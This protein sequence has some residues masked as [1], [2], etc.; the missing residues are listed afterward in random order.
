ML[1]IYASVNWIIIG[2]GNGLSPV[3]RQGITGTDA[4][5]LSIGSSGTNFS[6]IRVKIQTFHK[7]AFKN[8][9]CET[10]AILSREEWVSWS[11]N[12]VFSLS[13]K[14]TSGCRWQSCADAANT[15]HSMRYNI[16]SLT[17]RFSRRFHDPPIGV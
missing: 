1:H 2:S 6:E 4:D 10:A 17:V 13:V 9:F 14:G 16:T 8:V 5:L 7:N 12:S 3:R 15:G 11:Q